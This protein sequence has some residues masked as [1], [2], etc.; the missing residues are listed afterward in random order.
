MS[1]KINKS[2]MGKRNRQKGHQFEREIAKEFRNL[3]WK[4][5]ITSRA[6]DRSK[7]AGKVDL[8]NTSPLNIQ[9][10]SHNVFKNPIPTLKEMPQNNGF[11]NILIM[12]VKNKGD[13]VMMEKEDFYELI[14][15]MKT[16]GIF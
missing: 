2:Q 16:E 3:G 11:Y 6:G 1:K 4:K 8:L 10:K 9:T 7:D 13:F 5:T 15:V 12:R 14:E